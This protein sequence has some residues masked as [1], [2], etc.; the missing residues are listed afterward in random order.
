MEKPI[1][2]KPRFEYTFHENQLNSIRQTYELINVLLFKWIVANINLPLRAFKLT[3]EGFENKDPF[4]L[5]FAFCDLWNF[6]FK[7]ITNNIA[8]ILYS[9][10]LKKFYFI[11]TQ[12][13]QRTLRHDWKDIQFVM[14]FNGSFHF[15][16]SV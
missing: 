4:P 7:R 5:G 2:S 6:L 16:S 10:K 3:Y 13:I 9:L 14:D 12:N 8:I 1:D 15:I 11:T